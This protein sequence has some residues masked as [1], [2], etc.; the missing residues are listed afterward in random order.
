[1]YIWNLIILY[2]FKS[3]KKL[4]KHAVST[5]QHYWKWRGGGDVPNWTILRKYEASLCY[6]FYIS[7]YKKIDFYIKKSIPF[8][9]I[10]TF[11]YLKKSI[12]WYQKIDSWYQEIG[13]IFYIKKSDWFFIWSIFSISR[14]K[15]IDLTQSCDENPYTHRTIQ[16][17]TWQHKNTT[18]TLI[19]QLLRTDLWRSVRV[20]AVTQLVWLNRFT[21]AQPSHLPQQ[22]CNQKETH[23][24]IR[25]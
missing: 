15:G 23:L 13:L 25:K 24:N 21:S 11:F 8:L 22:S 18:K 5:F 1:M 17:A 19:T 9:D 20:T 10:R 6:L 2:C 16:K 12:S 14:E 3:S 4:I 7:W